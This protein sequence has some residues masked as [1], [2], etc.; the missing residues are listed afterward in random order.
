MSGVANE[1][2]ANLGHADPYFDRT[3]H[4]PSCPLD[5]FVDQ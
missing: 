2:A 1:R 4:I 3:I 5:P